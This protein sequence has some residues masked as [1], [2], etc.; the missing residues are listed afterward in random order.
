M[1]RAPRIEVP[2]ALYHGMSRGVKGCPTFQDDWDRPHFLQ[3]VGIFVQR[4]LLLVHAICLMSHYFQL[5]RETMGRQ[6]VAFRLQEDRRLVRGIECLR[7]RL[8]MLGFR[9]LPALAGHAHSGKDRNLP[10]G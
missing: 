1:A 10:Q 7:E 2:G 8:E 4:R 9:P 6:A 3:R 5:L